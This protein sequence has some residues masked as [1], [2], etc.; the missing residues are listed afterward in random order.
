MT[1]GLAMGCGLGMS[2]GIGAFIPCLRLKGLLPGRGVDAPGRAPWRA[3]E[4][5]EPPER[6]LL[7]EPWGPGLPIAEGLGPWD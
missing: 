5:P 7:R 4:D 2:E 1:V 6:P 3:G